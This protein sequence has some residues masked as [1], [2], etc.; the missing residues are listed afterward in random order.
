[1][2]LIKRRK[3]KNV[4]RFTLLILFLLI[5][6]ASLCVFIP[7]SHNL[8]IAEMNAQIEQLGFYKND[9]WISTERYMKNIWYSLGIALGVVLP[10]SGM[11]AIGIWIACE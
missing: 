6:I 9:L 8:K 7:L 5:I 2:I 3:M 1:M 4:V 11:G 10:L